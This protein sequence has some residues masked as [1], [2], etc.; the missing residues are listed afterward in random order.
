MTV[1]EIADIQRLLQEI[2]ETKIE[3]NYS[4]VPAERARDD[5]CNNYGK[6]IL[7]LSS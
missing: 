4:L 5:K 7:L 2:I 3:R 6:I 1:W